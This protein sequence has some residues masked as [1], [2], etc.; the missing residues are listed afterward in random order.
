V[1]CGLIHHLPKGRRAG[2]R[3]GD[4]NGEGE[5]R[6]K[7]VD[8]EENIRREEEREGNDERRTFTAY[9]VPVSILRAR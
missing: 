9:S 5:G 7:G 6:W 3:E 4:M 2:G 8:K 1:E